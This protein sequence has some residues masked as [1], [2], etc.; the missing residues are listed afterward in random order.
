MHNSGMM[1]CHAQLCFCNDVIHNDIIHNDVIY[2]DVTHCDVIHTKMLNMSTL[3]K[4]V[5]SYLAFFFTPLLLAKLTP[6]PTEAYG[7]LTA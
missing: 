2:Y 5:C 6:K 4:K 3:I 1:L 7:T